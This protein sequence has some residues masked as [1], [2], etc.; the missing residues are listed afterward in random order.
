LTE[1]PNREESRFALRWLL[2]NSPILFIVG[3]SWVIV[4]AVWLKHFQSLIGLALW[5]AFTVAILVLLAAGLRSI[6]NHTPTSIEVG[7]DAL[8]VRWAGTGRKS[9][10]ITF[11]RVTSIDPKG[12]IWTTGKGANV[13]FVP[14]SIH[15]KAVALDSA[16]D[17]SPYRLQEDV[18][19]LTDQNFDR[20]NSLFQQ[21]SVSESDGNP[22]DTTDPD[23]AP[24][25]PAGLSRDA[26]WSAIVQTELKCHRCGRDIDEAIPHLPGLCADC[27]V[28]RS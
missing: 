1:Y 21:W 14:A 15:F 19:Y 16:R 10:A 18:L 23:F 7:N 17:P 28:L 9:E 3:A 12:W 6:R 13:Q 27:S 25:I 5:L 11:D 26:A 24:K 22:L 2:A 8:T 4:L 20:V